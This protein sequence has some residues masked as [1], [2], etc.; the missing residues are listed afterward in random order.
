M[1]VMIIIAIIIFISIE[2]LLYMY[3]K[4]KDDIQCDVMIV[5]GAGLHGATISSAL[6]R[7]LDTALHY[8]HKFPQTR[9]IVS[10]GQGKDESVSEAYAMQQYLMNHGIDE[11]QIILEDTS[12]S[13]YTNFLNSK[14]VLGN[15][16]Q[17]IIVCTCDFHMY[18][19]C[20]I[21]RNMGFTPYRLPAK[22]TKVNCIKYYIREF[23]CVIKNYVTNT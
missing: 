15:Q 13:T 16:I 21:A 4:Y 3:G 6:K 10:G 14:Q 23:F 19:A 17:E 18:R 2:L 12:T 22:S 5:L 1:K 8:V 20:R 7:R 11:T 9:I